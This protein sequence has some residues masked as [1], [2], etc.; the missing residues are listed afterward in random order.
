M[1][2]TTL[3]LKEHE[4]KGKLFATIRVQIINKK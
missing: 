3:P 4:E 1:C 2:K